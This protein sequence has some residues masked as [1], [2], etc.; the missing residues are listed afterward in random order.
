MQRIDP[1]KPKKWCQACDLDVLKIHV[2]DSLDTA[3]IICQSTK[4]LGGLKLPDEI[5]FVASELSMCSTAAA[6]AARWTT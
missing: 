6:M 2:L 4:N 3:P 1:G 5:N